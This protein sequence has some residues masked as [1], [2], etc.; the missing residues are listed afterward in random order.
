[1]SPLN[2]NLTELIAGVQSD[3]PGAE[4]LAWIAVAQSRSKQLGEIGDQLVGHFVDQA[5]KSGASWSQIGDAIGVTKQ[6]AQQRWVSPTFERFTTR[7]RKAVVLSQERARTD[8]R[9]EI[10]TEHLLF[11]LLEDPDGLA[12]QALASLAGSLDAVRTA[13]EARLKTGDTTLK[14]HIPFAP[15]C[16]DALRRTLD[17]ALSLNHNYI[18]TEHILLSLLMTDGQAAV[19]LGELEIGYDATRAWLVERLTEIAAEP[20]K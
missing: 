20:G 7:A 4:P 9:T 6:A 13:V 15:D 3:L 1:M 5:R 17:E 10:G 2:V 16:K 14:G 19:I 18:G 12:A 11:G 8:R